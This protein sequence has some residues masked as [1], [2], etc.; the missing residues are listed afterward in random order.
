M[1]KYILKVVMSCRTLVQLQACEDW[2][3]DNYQYTEPELRCIGEKEEIDILEMI[4]EMKFY[5]ARL[6]E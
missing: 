1:N 2:A 4:R 6:C 5:T 3:Y